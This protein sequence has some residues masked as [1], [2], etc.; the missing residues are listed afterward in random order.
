MALVEC[1]CKSLG[2]DELCTGVVTDLEPRRIVRLTGDY[3]ECWNS[4]SQA[5]LEGMAIKKALAK[6][7][8]KSLRLVTSRDALD[9]RKCQD[10]LASPRQIERNVVTVRRE[11]RHA[12][13]VEKTA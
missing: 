8:A 5:L 11:R 3:Q 7:K 10:A 13:L 1:L 12:M 2:P 4:N 6:T 9:L